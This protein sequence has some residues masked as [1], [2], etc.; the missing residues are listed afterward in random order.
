MELI[1]NGTAGGVN[2]NK[3]VYQTLHYGTN[4]EDDGKYADMV[5]V[6]HYQVVSLMMIIIFLESIGQKEKLNGM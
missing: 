1:G 2:G 4:G 3:Q 6:I 5:L